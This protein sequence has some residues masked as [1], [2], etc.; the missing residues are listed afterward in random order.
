MTF[1]IRN[2]GTSLD[3]LISDAGI[4]LEEVG[5]RIDLLRGGGARRGHHAHLLDIAS[6]VDHL[7]PFNGTEWATES[8]EIYNN[9]KHA[10]RRDPT[11]DELHEMLIKNR[12]VF[13]VWIARRIG[14]SDSVIDRGMWRLKRGLGD[15]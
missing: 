15:A 12:L 1:S 2:G 10:D 6:E 13:R 11:A 7:L 4:G 9:V 5:H 14:V 8:T 3:G